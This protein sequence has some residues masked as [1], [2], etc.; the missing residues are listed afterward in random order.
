MVIGNTCFIKA[1]KSS[2]RRKSKEADRLFAPAEKT[3][4]WMV[5][6][7]YMAK[8]SRSNIIITWMFYPRGRTSK[9]WTGLALKTSGITLEMY[10]V[11]NNEKVELYFLIQPLGGYIYNFMLSRVVRLTV[12]MN[13]VQ[14]R[15]RGR[16]FQT[17][18]QATYWMI[19]HTHAYIL[20]L[21]VYVW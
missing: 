13:N 5:S 18:I 21:W 12:F 6:S 7:L 8:R 16:I 3:S 15:Y 17:V 19:L 20:C 11:P 9:Q 4:M 10:Y 14:I 1:T 2:A